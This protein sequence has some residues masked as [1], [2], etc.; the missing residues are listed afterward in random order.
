MAA[1][2]SA[3]E[4]TLGPDGN[5]S[6]TP[7][8]YTPPHQSRANNISTPSWSGLDPNLRM[9]LPENLNNV[10]LQ[11]QATTLTTTPFTPSFPSPY[12]MS[13]FP[14]YYP[15][16]HPRMYPQQPFM[17]HYPYPAPLTFPSAT[18]SVPTGFAQTR[19]DNPG[20]SMCRNLLS[21]TLTPTPGHATIVQPP[22]AEGLLALELYTFICPPH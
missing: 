4:P 21:Y 17:P 16:S 22:S 3:R 7:H 10:P 19:G 5:P 11:N 2:N 14:P 20:D 6:P 8:G 1:S 18:P 9:S 13:L 12:N 15:Y